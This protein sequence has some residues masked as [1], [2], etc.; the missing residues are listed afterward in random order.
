MKNLKIVILLIIASTLFFQADAQIFVQF[1]QVSDGEE[2]LNV[3]PRYSWGGVSYFPIKETKFVAGAVLEN[4]GLIFDVGPDRVVHRGIGIGPSIGLDIPIGEKFFARAAYVPE[5]FLHYKHKVFKNKDRSNKEVLHTEWFSD[6]M[7][8]FN[9]SVD[10]SIGH[11]FLALN[12]RYFFTD[13]LNQEYT[14]E[15]GSMPFQ[16]LDTQMFNIGITWNILNGG[17]DDDDEE[18]DEETTQVF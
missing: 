4:Q 17:D 18:P 12:V 3:I 16:N 1:G 11:R 8:W 2:E 7:N 9:H 15:D 5:I 6:R 13:L 10:F 14:A